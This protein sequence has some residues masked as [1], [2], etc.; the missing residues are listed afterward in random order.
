VIV[1]TPVVLLSYR[2]I[3]IFLA[4]FA[5]RL[6]QP[7]NALAVHFETSVAFASEYIPSMLGAPLIYGKVPDP[8]LVPNFLIFL[9]DAC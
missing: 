4:F 1:K 2:M 6:F 3:R 9:D 7:M 5:P 8:P